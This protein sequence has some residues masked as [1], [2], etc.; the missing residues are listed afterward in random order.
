MASEII[1]L[2][3]VN[4][5]SNYPALVNR[6]IASSG[7]KIRCVVACAEGAR[8]NH[9]QGCA[10]SSRPATAKG[11]LSAAANVIARA[12][13]TEW[14]DEISEPFFGSHIRRAVRTLRAGFGR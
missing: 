2:D 7:D 8:W 11:A 3:F 10:N 9:D 5:D 1:A 12:P 14:E 6:S 13:E 4:F